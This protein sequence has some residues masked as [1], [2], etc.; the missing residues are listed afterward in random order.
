MAGYVPDIQC[1]SW[2]TPSD[3]IAVVRDALGGDIELDPCSNHASVV[4]ARVKYELPLR[5]GLHESW[6]RRTI[7]VNPPYGTTRVHKITQLEFVGKWKDVPEAERGGYETTTI[8]DWLGRCAKAF[9]EHQ[10]EVI[11]LVPVTPETHGWQ[12][13]VWNHGTA[14]CFF[15]KRIKF[16]DPASGQMMTSGFPKPQCLIYWGAHSDRFKRLT[17]ILGAVV[18]IG[19]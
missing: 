6:D 10:S 14:I 9:M 12:R 11:A 3:I 18:I 1:R 15:N 7:Y 4:N 19:H 17:H 13:H 16:I 5:N 2:C 8:A